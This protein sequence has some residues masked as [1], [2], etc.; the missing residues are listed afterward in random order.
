M[1][2]PSKTKILIQFFTLCLMVIGVSYLISSIWVQKKEEI[3]EK[4]VLFFAESMTLAEFGVK[5]NLSTRILQEVFELKDKKGLQKQVSAFEA[6]EERISSKVDKILAVEAE[7]GSK[8]WQKILL[9]FIL[10]FVI[11]G[12]AF[13]LMRRGKITPEVRKILYFSSLVIFGV[14]LGADPSAM[15]TVKDAIGLYAE[16]GVIFPPRMIA[17]TVFLLIVLLANK[18]FCGWACQ[19][20][21]LQDLIFRLN[22]NKKDRK[23]VFKQVKL[24]F[25]V[26]NTIRVL[27]F[28]IFTVV[29][30]VWA[31]DIIE[32]IDPFKIYKP[33][34]IEV[35]G[36]AFMGGLLVLSIF[37]YRPWC[38]MFCPFGLVGWLVEKLAVFKIKVDYDK[39]TA[40]QSCAKA[41]P[42]TAM[43]SILKRDKVIPDCFA[44]GTCLESCKSG[45]L[46]FSFGKR[47]QPPAK[48][49][50]R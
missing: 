13:Y 21:T 9:K 49:F 38:T 5:N 37:V 41:C 4:Q 48:K 31:L 8:N 33:G 24:P 35:M 34:K 10:W 42:T 6:T 3:P 22:R 19:I 14:I 29:S 43:D 26:T 20:G 2:N 32:F 11:C 30:F 17:L 1:K 28:A 16:K 46:T 50:D 44:C 18:F 25:V 36:W 23:G 40:C 47:L 7:H 15:G 27:F 39:C 45:A 12:V